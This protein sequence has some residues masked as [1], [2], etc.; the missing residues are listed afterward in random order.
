MR[1]PTLEELEDAAALVY[2]HMQASAQ[3]N[4]PL[5]DQ[6]CGCSVTVKHENHNPTGAFKVRGGLVY[7]DRLAASDDRPAGVVAATRGNH[8]QSIAL[9][10]AQVGLPCV[11]VVPENNSGDKNRAMAAFGAD[12]VV[13]GA[14]FNDALDHARAL[15]EQRGWHL[16]PSFHRDLVLGVGSYALELFRACPQLERVYVPVGLGSGICGMISAR[17]ALGLDTEIVAVVSTEAD[18]YARSLE[19]GHS[20]ATDTASTLADGMAVHTPN[21]DALAFMLGEVARVVR[22]GDDEILSAMSALFQ[23]CHNVVEGAGAATL[24][25]LLR[26]RSLNVGKAVAIVASGGNIDPRLFSRALIIQ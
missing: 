2:R 15:A 23:D 17:N 24:A 19:A 26:E 3:L 22:V 12:L 21:P 6:R 4:W 18:C 9:A 11:V 1:Q 14:D 7:L 10:A 20:I 25:A 8:G 16:V 13:H 5:L